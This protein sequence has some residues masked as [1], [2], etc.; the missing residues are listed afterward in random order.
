MKVKKSEYDR[1]RRAENDAKKACIP[2]N[3]MNSIID[4]KTTRQRTNEDVSN[5]TDDQTQSDFDTKVKINEEADRL[6]EINRLRER[7]L[8]MKN[9]ILQ[10]FKKSVSNTLDIEIQD[11]AERKLEILRKCDTHV[12]T[13]LERPTVRT[14]AYG[15][16]LC[17]YVSTIED[18]PIDDGCSLHYME[19]K[20]K[21]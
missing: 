12:S 17:T 14:I 7:N 1:V 8:R 6:K 21:T 10:L 19:K 18:R 3:Q 20:K 2:A 9:K 13:R 15:H 16:S 5:D 4:I 11:D